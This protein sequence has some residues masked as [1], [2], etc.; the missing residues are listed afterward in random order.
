M[1]LTL[2]E[3]TAPTGSNSMTNCPATGSTDRPSWRN[4]TR[5]PTLKA[6]ASSSGF[7]MPATCFRMATQ[8]FADDRRTHTLGAQVAHFLELDEIEEGKLVGNRDQ[9]GSL[10]AR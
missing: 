9:T 5:L 7:S 6:L 2:T 10:P 1:G 3:T 8:G 4:A